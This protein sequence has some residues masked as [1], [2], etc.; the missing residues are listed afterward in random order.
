MKNKSTQSGITLIALVVTI[1]VLLILA[2][3]T[4]AFV[5]SDGGIFQAAQD[6]KDEQVVATIRD[7]VGQIN[8]VVA[9]KYWKNVANGDDDPE[10]ELVKTEEEV[11]DNPHKISIESF[12]PDNDNN[13]SIGNL[14][15][16]NSGEDIYVTKSIEGVIKNVEFEVLI[17]GDEDKVYT[18]KFSE[19]NGLVTVTPGGIPM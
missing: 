10:I 11:K 7:Y 3:I 17:G 13:Y 1:V 6:A 8:G 16:Y 2:G 14:F 4:I 5:L 18:V 19:D 15:G 9:A 12:F